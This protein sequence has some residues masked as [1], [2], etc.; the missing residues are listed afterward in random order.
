[1]RSKNACMLG[2]HTK[3]LKRFPRYDEIIFTNVVVGD[4]SWIQYFE[5]HPKIRNRVWLTK[6]ERKLV[7]P[8]G[9][10]GH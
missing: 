9:I 3:L 4:E 6:N 10:P 2:Q 5:P 8:Q 1:M 7:L